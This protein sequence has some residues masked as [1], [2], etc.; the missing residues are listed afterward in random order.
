MSRP[1]LEESKYEMI[2][3]HVLDPDNSPLSREKRELSLQ[4]FR[5]PFSLKNRRGSFFLIKSGS[6]KKN[7]KI[8]P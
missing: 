7:Q 3:A 8:N 1:A 6:R 2:K 4:F 5:Y